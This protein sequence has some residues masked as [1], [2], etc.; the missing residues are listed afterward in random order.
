VSSDLSELILGVT[1]RDTGTL[2]TVPLQASLVD[3]AVPDAGVDRNAIADSPAE[4]RV[5]LGASRPQV[6]VVSP[7]NTD[8]VFVGDGLEGVGGLAIC[9][10]STGSVE[11]FDV[12]GPVSA[13]SV[14]PSGT[15]VYGVLDSQACTGSSPCAGVFGFDVSSRALLQ[16]APLQI[17][18]GPRGIAAG[19]ETTLLSPSITVDPLVLV[20]SLDGSIYLVNGA[21]ME[22]IQTSTSTPDAGI[23]DAGSEDAGIPDTGIADAGSEDAGAPD[24]GGEDGG[25]AGIPGT[26]EDAGA[27][28]DAGIA[29]SFFKL[30]LSD[31]T[32]P[33][34]MVYAPSNGFFYAVF[35]GSSVLAEIRPNEIS[36]TSISSPPAGVTELH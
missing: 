30:T 34:A 33:G 27:V 23:A 28:P 25:D 9:T 5:D 11:R 13:L 20:S 18:G 3:M 16:T 1:V 2:Y 7:T 14:D 19:V 32:V 22:L 15:F 29:I 26:G 31:A 36:A 4:A 24:A 35:A 17:P 10:L 8:L 6:L 12:G 21:T